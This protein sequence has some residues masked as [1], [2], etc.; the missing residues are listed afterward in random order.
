MFVM[1]VSDTFSAVSALLIVLFYTH[2]FIVFWLLSSKFAISTKSN[3]LF[4][5]PSVAL[6]W[7]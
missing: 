2:F 1:S 3:V 6:R 4:G 7:G 5:S